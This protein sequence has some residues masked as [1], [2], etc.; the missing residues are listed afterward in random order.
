SGGQHSGSDRT[1]EGGKPD[2][3][4]FHICMTDSIPERRVTT[5][6]QRLDLAQVEKRIRRRREWLGQKGLEPAHRMSILDGGAGEQARSPAAA[7]GATAGG[8]MQPNS[9][10]RRA[11]FLSPLRSLYQEP[12]WLK[13]I[14]R[15]SQRGTI[16]F[17]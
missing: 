5:R 7:V 16:F 10:V 3:L 15:R 9:V 17:G 11:R 1:S 8:T 6:R 2:L 14:E 12:L 13:G 4:I